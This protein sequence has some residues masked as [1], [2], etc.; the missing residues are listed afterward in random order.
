VC[1]NNRFLSCFLGKSYDKQTNK[2]TKNKQTNK[3][4]HSVLSMFRIFSVKVHVVTAKI[5]MRDIA[6]HI[7]PMQCK[8][9]RV[10]DVFLAKHSRNFHK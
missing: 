7:F 2:Q 8:L 1:E 5:S 3:Q 9:S 6:K 4:T 10:F